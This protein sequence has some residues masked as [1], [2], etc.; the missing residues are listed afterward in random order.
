MQYRLHV[1]HPESKDTRLTHE[2]ICMLSFTAWTPV[3]MLAGKSLVTKWFVAEIASRVL[4]S[5]RG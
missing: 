2:S 1:G 4:A 3:F 5:A